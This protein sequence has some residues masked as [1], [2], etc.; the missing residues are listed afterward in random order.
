MLRVTSFIASLVIRIHYHYFPSLIA[1]F[2]SPSIITIFTTHI[3]ICNVHPPMLLFTY[4]PFFLIMVQSLP[5]AV[6]GCSNQNICF[7]RFSIVCFVNFPPNH[8]IILVQLSVYL[9]QPVP[10]II[11]CISLH[12]IFPFCLLR[13]LPIFYPSLLPSYF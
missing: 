13:L 12:C 4:Q 5:E 11:Q 3:V 9:C 6:V 10:L 8:S 1:L 2:S 7:F